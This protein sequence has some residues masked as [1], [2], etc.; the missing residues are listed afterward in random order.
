MS[1]NNYLIGVKKN[2]R[3]LYFQI[4]QNTMGNKSID[5]NFT[6]EENKGRLEGRQVYVYDD[7]TNISA[8]WVGLKRLIKVVRTVSSKKRD[9]Q[10]TAYFISSIELSAEEFNKGV[11]SHWA[12]ENSLHWVKDVTYKE[13]ASKI[14]T[15]CAP[16]NNSI[17][18]NI[19]INILRKN[20]YKNLASAQ[21]LLANNIPV[22]YGLIE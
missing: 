17:F 21:R 4:E 5:S 22:I 13:D 11:R 1:K 19:A 16:E 8:K 10:E 2:Q 9:Y 14:R 3:R 12:I 18:K 15:G 7:L 6:I 20:G